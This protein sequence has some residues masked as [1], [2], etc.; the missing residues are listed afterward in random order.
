MINTLG[1][2][3]ILIKVLLTVSTLGLIF[4]L[5]MYLR[6]ILLNTMKNTQNNLGIELDLRIEDTKEEE[7]LICP[8][9]DS[10]QKSEWNCC[11]ICGSDYLNSQKL[12][13]QNHDYLSKS[14]IPTS[15]NTG[16]GN[17]HEKLQILDLSISVL[18]NKVL[19]E[20][21][22]EILELSNEEISSQDNA[23]NT[24]ENITTVVSGE[25]INN[26]SRQFESSEEGL[27]EA[28]HKEDSI[29]TLE[30][31]IKEVRPQNGKNKNKGR[32]KRVKSF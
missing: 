20:E 10:E 7:M 31:S 30:L 19:E 11:P 25:N 18:E 12:E 4:G 8:V 17:I 5:T 28:T 27:G 6:E 9:C 23:N 1:L 15:N 3:I 22:K 2:L 29:E 13:I 24:K 16:E 32:N 26:E 14:E 21:N